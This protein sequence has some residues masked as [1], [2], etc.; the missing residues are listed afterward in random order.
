MGI[1]YL[2]L[3]EGITKYS[4]IKR[5]FW[6]GGIIIGINWLS[7]NLFMILILDVPLLDPVIL[8]GLNIISII[9][10]VLVFENVV[11]APRPKVRPSRFYERQFPLPILYT[12]AKPWIGER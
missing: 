10:G 2:L 9:V 3:E 8:A 6:F 4:L 7:F 5:S 1:I 12:S 11:E